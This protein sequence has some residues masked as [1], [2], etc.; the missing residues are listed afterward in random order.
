MHAVHGKSLASLVPV[1]VAFAAVS[2]MAG[3][4][5][6]PTG[7][8]Q[9]V[10]L[11]AF[12]AAR[13][14]TAANTVDAEP[15]PVIGAD[16]RTVDADPPPTYCEAAGGANSIAIP[17]L[18]I[19]AE[20]AYASLSGGWLSPPPGAGVSATKRGSD[21]SRVLAGTISSRGNANGTLWTLPQ[22]R[23]G[24]DIW[25]TDQWCS[26]THWVA[27]SLSTTARTGLPETPAPAALTIAACDGPVA[28]P[29]PGGT[30]CARL[31]VVVAAPLGSVTGDPGRRTAHAARA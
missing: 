10:P 9:P 26:M 5:L 21:G 12:A 22:I 7:Q 29:A 20:Y 14:F 2:V 11:D 25:L 4:F 13:P 8:A 23:P 6:A 19:E 16:G 24:D 28:L 27:V 3:F 30:Q 15:R 18:A 17:R 1:A 31:A